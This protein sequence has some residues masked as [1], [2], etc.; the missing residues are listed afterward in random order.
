MVQNR[1]EEATKDFRHE[2]AQHPEETF[3]VT[4]FAGFLMRRSQLDEARTV[5]QSSFDRDPSQPQVA[6]ML[7]S[8]QANDNLDQAIAT[9][10]KATDAKPKEAQLMSQLVPLLVRKG[11]NAEAREVAGKVLDLAG[12]D[13]SLLNNGAYVAAEAGG[14]MAVAEKAARK[15]LDILDGQTSQAAVGEA[16][17]QSFMRSSLLTATWDTLGYI[18]LQQKK[19]DEALDYLEAAWRNRPDVTVGLH[20]GSALEAAGKKSEALRIYTLSSSDVRGNSVKANADLQPL[21]DRMAILKKDGV[22]P[23]S[24][25][26]KELSLQEERT[27]KLSL[28]SACKSYESATFRL[29]L[30]SSGQPEVL[31]VGGQDLPTGTAE[32]LKGLKLPHLV[33][34]TS[35]ARVL[36]DAAVTCSAQQSAA[37]VVLMPLGG[38]NAER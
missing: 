1:P 6:G 34:S 11:E 14:D 17:Q 12:E 23:P 3:V 26:S 20:Y 13:P 38:I 15:A 18:L 27:F 7:A 33:P 16:N 31:Q 37:Y 4:L 36:R 30:S 9:L 35:T 21:Q 22:R 2:L 19:T 24:A 25:G 10:H 8:L 5:L 29:Q 28:S 32:S